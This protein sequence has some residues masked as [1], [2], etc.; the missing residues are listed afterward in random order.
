MTLEPL[1]PARRQEMTRRHLL[2]AAATVFAE[3]GFHQATLDEVATAAGFTKGAVYSNFGSKD[4]LFLALLDDR[5][6]R[7]QAL[8]AELIDSAETNRT[9]ID[10]S[11]QLLRGAAFFG[12]DS[13]SALYLEFV[14][15]A[16]RHPEAQA[17]LAA[18][19]SRS[20]EYV[21]RLL[22]DEFDRAGVHVRYE[23]ADIAAV[24]IAVFEGIGIG[25]LVD[26]S[27]HG[28]RAFDTLL[29]ILATSLL[30]TSLLPTSLSPT[31]PE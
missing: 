3:H 9:K 11:A 26:P 10:L 21:T 30:P 15:Y 20:R 6:D 14:V 18:I 1:T 19:A 4:D 17:K 24:L 29:S 25:R 5:I 23:P 28:E 16:R 13:W 12:N 8:L 2:E 7:Q 31:S 27:A 22:A